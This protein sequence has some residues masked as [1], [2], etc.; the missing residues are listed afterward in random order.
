MWY[1]QTGEKI[2]KCPADAKQRERVLYSCSPDIFPDEQPLHILL[3]RVRNAEDPGM[4]KKRQ[5]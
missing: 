3:L 5:I 4:L 1:H 2:P